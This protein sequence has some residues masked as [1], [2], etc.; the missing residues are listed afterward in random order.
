M[1][2]LYLNHNN[3][4]E[5]PISIEGLASLKYFHLTKNKIKELLKVLKVPSNLKVL[6][7]Q[8]NSIEKSEN[9]PKNLDKKNLQIYY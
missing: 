6:D 2:N 9:L 1:E 4:S 5:I 8:Y 7:L 3:L